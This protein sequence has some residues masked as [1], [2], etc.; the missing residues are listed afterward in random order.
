MAHSDSVWM[1]IGNATGHGLTVSM[2]DAPFSF[3]CSHYSSEQLTRTAHA[4]ELT[5]LKETVVNIDLRQSGIG[6]NSCGPA[7][8][9]KYRIEETH[10]ELSFVIKAGFFDDT[11]RFV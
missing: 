5:P 9:D 7:L 10:L 3:N 6:S 4:Y 8:T 2:A 1:C 11:D